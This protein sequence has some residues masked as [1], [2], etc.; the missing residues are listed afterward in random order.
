MKFERINK[1]NVRCIVD[2]KDLEEFQVGIDD[3]FSNSEK[4]HNFIHEMVHEAKKKVNY[5]PV[6][7]ILSMQ[8]SVISENKIAINL[9]ENDQTQNISPD[10][11]Q[12]F[13]KD[14]ELP[15]FRKAPPKKKPD[16]ESDPDSKVV[17]VPPSYMRVFLF[18]NLADIIRFSGTVSSRCQVASSLFKNDGKYYLCL[19]RGNAS[20]VN[21]AKTCLRAND[22]G[23]Q[24][25]DSLARRAFIEEQYE[26]IFPKKAINSLN[27]IER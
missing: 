19:E 16:K 12:D 13:S 24:I 8:I 4:I 18:A 1:N 22:F 23:K 10:V 17:E 5:H 9:S 15:D 14:A 20:V 25:S 6:E 2:K 27:K 26:C 11:L 21:F 7:G 3:F